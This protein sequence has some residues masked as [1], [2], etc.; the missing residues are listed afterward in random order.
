MGLQ[1]AIY[2]ASEQT[3]PLQ[4]LLAEG[5]ELVLRGTNLKENPLYF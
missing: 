1:W 4:A 5:T 3:D 2:N